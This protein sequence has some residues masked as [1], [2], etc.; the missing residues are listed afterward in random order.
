MPSK[1]RGLTSHELTSEER[2]RGH[3]LSKDDV[4]KARA[5]LRA[6]KWSEEH[7]ALGTRRSSIECH[8]RR[9]YGIAPEDWARMWEEQRGLCAL[10][11]DPMD[12]D[13]ANVDHDHSTGEVRGLLCPRCNTLLV[14]QAERIGRLGLRRLIA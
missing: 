4:A 9:Q 5:I 8:W 11:L 6:R 12:I 3:T 10:C 14:A 2:Q 1:Y 7:S 13:K